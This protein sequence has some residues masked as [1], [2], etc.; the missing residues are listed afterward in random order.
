MSDAARTHTRPLLSSSLSAEEF[1]RWY[2]LKDELIDY[3]REYDLPRSGAKTELADRIVAHLSGRVVT[4]IV[5]KKLPNSPMPTEFSINTRIGVGWHCSQPL[6]AFFVRYCGR[7]FRFSEALRAFIA[8][9]SGRTLG[10]AIAFYEIAKDEP[11]AEIDPQFE[12]NR[13]VREF[14]R[15]HPHATHSDVVASWKAKRSAP[16]DSGVGS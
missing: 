13:H 6:R 15:D 5:R 7:G 12:Y 1:R 8:T 11:R 16:N 10:D 4:T 9:N 2:W 14:R 3:C